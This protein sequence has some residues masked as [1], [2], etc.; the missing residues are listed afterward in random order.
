MR[1]LIH[2]P[3]RMY[4]S[5]PRCMPIARLGL[6]HIIQIIGEGPSDMGRHI[7]IPCL[8]ISEGPSPKALSMCGSWYVQCTSLLIGI[9]A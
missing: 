2:K 4:A 8:P 9:H 3:Q 5:V 7:Y 6:I 1:G